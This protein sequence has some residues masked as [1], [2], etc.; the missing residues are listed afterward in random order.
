MEMNR[1]DSTGAGATSSDL[2]NFKVGYGVNK[3]GQHM[4]KTVRKYYLLR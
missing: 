4:R 1:K 3:K 2:N